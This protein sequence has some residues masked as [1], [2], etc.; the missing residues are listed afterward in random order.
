[1]ELELTGKVSR[2]PVLTVFVRD[3]PAM[4]GNGGQHNLRRIQNALET[5]GAKLACPSC[6][7]VDWSRDPDPVVLPIPQAGGKLIPA[8]PAYMLMCR[9]CGFIRLHSTKVLLEH[10]T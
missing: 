8:V 2:G 4:E 6:D 7:H 5:A 9:N 3:T 1:V 10:S